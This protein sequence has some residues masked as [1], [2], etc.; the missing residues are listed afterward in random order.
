MVEASSPLQSD[1]V[2]VGA[3]PAG[4]AAALAAARAGA[5]VAIVDA[6]PAVGG[7]IWRARGGVP[8]PPALAY[9]SALEAAGVRL[10]LRTRVAWVLPDRSLLVEGP[11]GSAVLCWRRLVI[12]TGARE[13]L[14][15]FPGWTL[16][17]V[18]GAG[19]LQALVKGGW[20][21][22]GRR[23]V[24]AGTGPLLL[25]SAATLRAAGARIVA[26]CDESGGAA[27]ARFTP[28]LLAHPAKAWQALGLGAALAGVRLRTGV[29]VREVLG[30]G[31]VE[32]VVLEPVAGT[33]AARSREE[34]TD[35]RVIECDAVATGW[36]L[37][38]QTELA[39]ALGC[40]MVS[41][42]GTAAIR[43][44]AGQR[45]TVADVFAAGECT[46][47]AG[48]RAA[49]L[50]GEIAGRAAGAPMSEVPAG[51]RRALA[52]ERRFARALE[53]SFPAPVAWRDRVTDDTLVC[54]CEDVRWGAIRV[55]PDL[56]AA[57]LATRCGMGHC[58]G[59]LCHDALVAM[60][61]ASR[62][63]PRP[64]LAPIDLGALLAIGEGDG[65]DP[66]RGPASTPSEENP[67]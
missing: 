45:T 56:R 31:R 42:D 48:A 5:S 26:L 1:V 32:R 43:V 16:P 54:R 19:G 30:D 10:S 20:P 33:G 17:G 41:H 25:A 59:R 47:V 27:W 4:L 37:S 36:G 53:A 57:K 13:R 66:G 64:P 62:L 7:Q 15:P 61:G 24:V 38:P 9:R 12:A 39:H 21:I 50:A 18:F 40:A 34:A 46:G 29:R 51:T 6:A 22:A 11:S 23:V 2:V 49:V 28:A 60:T 63:P 65:V 8:A 44:D 35:C 14:L 67:R 52:R 3:G 55:H 58:Q